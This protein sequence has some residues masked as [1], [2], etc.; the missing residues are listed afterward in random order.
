ML[1]VV[2][3]ST[4]KSKSRLITLL[5]S[6]LIFNFVH[7]KCGPAR[8]AATRWRRSCQLRW[9]GQRAGQRGGIP[10]HGHCTGERIL[11]LWT[12]HKQ[13]QALGEDS[14]TPSKRGKCVS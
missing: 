11:P 7:G 6:S 8:L 12:L 14:T 13:E 3:G 10:T 1:K 2:L 9:R 4:V 5:V